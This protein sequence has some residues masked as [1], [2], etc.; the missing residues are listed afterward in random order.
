MNDIKIWEEFI[1]YIEQ[2]LMNYKS[3]TDMKYAEE[4]SYLNSR[5]FYLVGF[6]LA[7]NEKLVDH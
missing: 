2:K 6:L 7:K 3:D 4:N 1:P 5:D